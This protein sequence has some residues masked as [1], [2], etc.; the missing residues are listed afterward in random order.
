VTRT[1]LIVGYGNP[2]RGDDGIGQAVARALANETALD[3]VEV[4][5]CHQ[6]TPELAERFAAVDLVVLVD[7][8]DGPNPGSVAVT[9]LQEATPLSSGLWHHV[10]P[11]ALLFMSGRLYGRSPDAFLI[12]V[13]AGSLALNEGLSAAVEAALPEVIAAVR[14]LLIQPPPSD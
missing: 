14:R 4:V 12:T 6:L 13:G 9:R 1:A 2:L 10:D 8:K 3:G 5:C 11:E 7:A